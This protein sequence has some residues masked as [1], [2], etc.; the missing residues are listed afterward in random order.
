MRSRV[1]GKLI[2]HITDRKFIIIRIQNM[3]SKIMHK[4]NK[5]KHGSPTGNRKRTSDKKLNL[6]PDWRAIIVLYYKANVIRTISVWPYYGWSDSASEWNSKVSFLQWWRICPTPGH[7]QCYWP[8][9]QSNT[10]YDRNDVID[11]WEK[12]TNYYHQNVLISLNKKL[13]LQKG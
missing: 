10:R 13:V 1:S 6:T 3:N 5:W 4:V 2:L 9:D 7:S 12:G 8:R 11:Q